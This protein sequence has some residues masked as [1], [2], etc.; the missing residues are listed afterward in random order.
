LESQDPLAQVG[1]RIRAIRAKRRLTIDELSTLSRVQAIDISQIERTG[2]ASTEVLLKL[3]KAL[4]VP[5][6]SF[7]VDEHDI[8]SKQRGYY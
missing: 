8:E 4:D 1:H 6:A 3:A 5:V 7:F 2:H